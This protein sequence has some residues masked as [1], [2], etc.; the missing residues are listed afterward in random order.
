M[1]VVVIGQ[2]P[3]GLMFTGLLTYSGA[4]VVAVEPRADRAVVAHRFGA[5]VVVPPE[6]YAIRREVLAATNE[7]GAD[8]VIVTVPAVFGL[9]LAS[10]IV[11]P[12]GTVLLFASTHLD[13]PVTIDAG[14]ICHNEV[15]LI[16]SYSSDITL[17]AEAA[18]IL[19]E[20]PFDWGSLV[21]HVLPLREIRKAIEIATHPPKG[22]LKVLIA[23]WK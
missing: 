17:Q 9:P 4:R 20:K 12:G 11:R 7:R 22:A 15:N 1:D 6:H 2:G 14:L 8:A 18:Q 21:T 23:P 10:D 5:A 16:G 13:E 19:F 3:I